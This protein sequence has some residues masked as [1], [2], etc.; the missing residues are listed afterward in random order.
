V[1]CQECRLSRLRACQGE[2]CK[3]KLQLLRMGLRVVAAEHEAG[4]QALTV[5]WW[6][7]L[8]LQEVVAMIGGVSSEK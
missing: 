1:E 7:L 2:T 8:L 4:K 6:I 3:R 5:V